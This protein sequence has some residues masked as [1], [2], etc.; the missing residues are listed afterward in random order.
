M[1]NVQYPIINWTNAGT[2]S[3][4]FDFVGFQLKGFAMPAGTVASAT[5]TILAADKKDGVYKAFKNANGGA[6]VT[7]TMVTNGVYGLT[8]DFMALLNSLKHI[9]LVGS[10]SE[11]AGFQIQAI[12]EPR[13]AI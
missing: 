10:S 3:D 6:A 1:S 4:P 12:V 13:P 11:A 2:T 9:K 8:A 5:Y 7:L